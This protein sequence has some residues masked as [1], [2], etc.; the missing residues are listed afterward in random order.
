MDADAAVKLVQKAGNKEFK[1]VKEFK[2][3]NRWLHSSPADVDADA[4]VKLVQKAVGVT[5]ERRY[6]LDS[7][8][9]Q[10]QIP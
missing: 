7:E 8:C 4:A 9:S 6:M 5:R 2:D 3:K 10:R 1:E